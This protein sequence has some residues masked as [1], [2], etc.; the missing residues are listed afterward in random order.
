MSY[1]F[2]VLAYLQ[3]LIGKTD[4]EV[5]SQVTE[6]IDLVSSLLGRFYLIA[7]HP[8]GETS[9]KSYTSELM[10][11]SGRLTNEILLELQ[12]LDKHITEQFTPI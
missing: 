8:V 12:F 6:S 5:I 7:A 10:K 9:P 3:L 4:P 1:V 11:F 2:K